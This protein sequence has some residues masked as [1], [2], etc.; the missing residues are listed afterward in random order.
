MKR[1]LGLF[2]VLMLA[3]VAAWFVARQMESLESRFNRVEIGMSRAEVESIMGKG[4]SHSDHEP[5]FHGWS[6]EEA[7]P[8]RLWF[9]GD[10]T[11]FFLSSDYPGPIRSYYVLF[12]GDRIKRKWIEPSNRDVASC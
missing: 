12:E 2:A 10:A 1:W 4:W 8:I 7:G 3:G 6:R 11:L 9:E 5:A